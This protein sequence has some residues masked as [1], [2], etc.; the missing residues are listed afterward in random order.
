[1]L[2]GTEYLESLRDGRQVYVYGERVSDVTTHPAFRN[3]A[4]TVVRMYDALHNPEL[5]ETQTKETDTGSRTRTHKFFVSSRSAQELLEARDAIATWARLGYGFVSRS[6][7]YKASF[8]ATLGSNPEYYASFHENAWHWYKEVQERVWFVNH[9]F[10]N[11]NVDRDKPLHEVADVFL[12]IQK[13]TD[14]GVVV[15]G[16]KM[17]ATGFALTNFNFIAPSHQMVASFR[18]PL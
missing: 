3:A 16:A 6:P 18:Y 7:D 12:H 13:E 5:Q 11:P 8:I 14:A 9:A 4:R 17:V 1:M 10:V 15:S 2:T